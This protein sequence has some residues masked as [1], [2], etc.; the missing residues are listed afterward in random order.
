[1]TRRS[2]HLVCYDIASPERL[3]SAL[4]L[5]RHYATG[6]QKS[7]HECWLTPEELGELTQLLAALL[8]DRRDRVLILPLDPLRQTIPLGCARSPADDECIVIGS[9]R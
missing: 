3:R 9:R 1:M 4:A 6:G 2:L 7:V 5:S 8:D